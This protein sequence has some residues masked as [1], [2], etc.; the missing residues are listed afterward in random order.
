MELFFRMR[1]NY[2]AALMLPALAGF[3]I[4]AQP[5]QTPPAAKGVLGDVITAMTFNIRV[6]TFIDGPNRWDKRKG[7]V[8]DL[9]A[10]HAPDVVGLQEAKHGQYVEIRQALPAYMGYGV[11]RNNGAES[12]EMCP[13]LYRGDRYLKTDSGTFWFSDTPEKAGSKDWGNWPPRICSWVRLTDRKTQSSFY[14]YN[15]HLDHMSQNSR[16]KSIRLLTQ[17]IAARK[18]DDPY[19]VMGDF[20]MKINNSAMKYLQ[21]NR[22][23]PM[24]DA[25]TSLHGDRTTVGTRPGFNGSSGPKIDHIPLST[26]L[27][28]LQVTIDNR[29]YNG[30]RPSDHF[31]VIAKVLMPSQAFAEAPEASRE[32]STHNLF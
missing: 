31:P 11:G 9:I 7:Y 2:F 23:A 17:K 20:N 25:W 15:V 30:R 1:K 5:V 27:R 29:K 10:D 18:T 32:K 4:A 19:I 8:Y 22:T 24:A 6:D 12:G 16:K 14:V 26:E 3:A 21:M 13:I 28:P